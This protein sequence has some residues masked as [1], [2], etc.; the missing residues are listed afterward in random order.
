MV[1]NRCSASYT[2]SANATSGTSSSITSQPIEQ[3]VENKYRLSVTQR[4]S[5]V[6]RTGKFNSGS[7]FKQHY[8]VYSDVTTNTLI[9]TATFNG[10]V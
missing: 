2:G 9:S 4:Y 10:Y 7:G 1:E 6:T 3:N 5:G 8:A